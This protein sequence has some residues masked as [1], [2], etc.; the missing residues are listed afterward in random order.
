MYFLIFFFLASWRASLLVGL[1]SSR[2]QL[3]VVVTE[4]SSVGTML[5]VADLTSK[6]ACSQELLS[7]MLSM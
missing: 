6:E 1:V 4:I 7:Q 2:I 3:L 5:G